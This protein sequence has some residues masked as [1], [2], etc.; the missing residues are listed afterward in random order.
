M[1]DDI[2]TPNAVISKVT[3]PSG[4]TYDIKDAQARTDIASLQNDVSALQSYTDYL[5]V[6]STYIYDGAEINEIEINEE[7]IT[8]AVGNIV[9]YGSLEFIYNGEAWQEFGDLSALSNMLGDLAYHDVDD[10][11][12]EAFGLANGQEFEG[13]T[14]T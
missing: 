14:A 12:V 2:V 1:A 3:L 10:L 7:T 6:T 4:T 8:P 13:T 9:N 11:Y 5:G